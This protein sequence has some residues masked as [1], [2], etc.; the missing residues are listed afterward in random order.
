MVEQL[1]EEEAP[2]FILAFLGPWIADMSTLPLPV[3]HAIL[4]PA[5]GAAPPSPG[6]AWPGG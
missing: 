2:G 6:R 3:R 1:A 4:A 5:T